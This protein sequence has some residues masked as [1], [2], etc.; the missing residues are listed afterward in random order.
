M[1][2]QYVSAVPEPTSARTH[3]PALAAIAVLIALWGLA[4]WDFSTLMYKLTAFFPARQADGIPIIQG[5]TYFLVALPAAMFHR[6]FGYKLGIMMG[7][8]LSAFGPFLIYPTIA[9]HSYPAFATAGI[10]MTIGWPFLETCL[11]P[12]ATELGQR[13][14]AVRRL[15]FVQAFFPVGLVIGAFVAQAL[16]QFDLRPGQGWADATA[17]PF[18]VVGI[19]VLLLALAMEKLR[20]PPLASDRRQGRMRDELRELL[21]RKPVLI[22]LAAIFACQLAQALIW[23]VVYGY[24]PQELPHAEAGLAATAFLICCILAC[25][26][27]FGGTALMRWIHPL[28]LLSIAMTIAIALLAASAIVRGQVGL[29]LLLSAS[30]FMAIVYP[31]VFGT[32]IQDLGALKKTASGLLVTAAG[33]GSASESVLVYGLR[34]MMAARLIMLAAIPCFVMVLV[35][36]LRRKADVAPV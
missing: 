19:A 8:S 29:G 16:L 15:N 30:V 4:Q 5:V 27:R 6:R 31:T 1:N 34:D 25:V 24:I 3:A 28:A 21:S 22:G 20:L 33:I 7:L 13:Q 9:N 32:V 23:G 11:N 2:R 35:F 36:A 12:L 10:V 14:F 26:G 18:V 17:R